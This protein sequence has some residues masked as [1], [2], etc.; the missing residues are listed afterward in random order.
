[1]TDLRAVPEPEELPR[2]YHELASLGARVEGRPVPWRH[3]EPGAEE[4]LV[5]AAQAARKDPRLLWVAV[6]LLAERYDT[7]DPLKLRRAA[8]RSRWPATVAVALEFAR[9]AAPSA[10]LDDYAHFVTARI[11]AADGERFFLG[12]RAFA[13]EQARRDAEESLAEYKRWGYLGRELPFSKELATTARGRLRPAER[14][15]LLRRIASRRG[16]VSLREYLEAL[17]GRAS[18]RQASRDLASAGFLV[19][20]GRTRGATWRYVGPGTEG[21]GAR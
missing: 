10:E 5:L 19:R 8:A 4:L 7:F 6:E 18:S 2:L 20:R 14:R 21:A 15:N 16:E 3:G 12:T 9:E 13:G 1:V 17:K 11:P